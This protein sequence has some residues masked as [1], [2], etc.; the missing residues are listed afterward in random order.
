MFGKLFLIIFL[1]LGGLQISVLGQSKTVIK[2]ARAKQML[3]GKHK[4]SLQWIS[5]DYFG[6]A[7]VTE[8]G[9]VL[10]LKG[11]QRSRK[12]NDFVRIDGIITEVRAR[13]FVFDGKIIT[14]V[15]SINNGEPCERSGEMLFR[16]TGSRKYWRLQQMDN[17]CDDVTDYVDIF[18]R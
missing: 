10:Y 6:T 2:N 17:P 5:W 18:F 9:G 16:I 13:E 8:R 1:V 12:G 11:E 3:L 4:F 15:A 7:T 14:Q